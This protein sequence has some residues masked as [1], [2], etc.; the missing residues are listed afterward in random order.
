[1][2]LNSSR[3]LRS[4]AIAAV[5]LLL[6]AGAAFASSSHPAVVTDPTSGHAAKA[7]DALDATKS[8]V[9]EHA[10]DGSG[11]P[12][13]KESS[14][15]TKAPEAS[16][17]SEPTKAPEASESSEPTE[18][19]ETNDQDS[20]KDQ[21]LDKAPEAGGPGASNAPVAPQDPDKDGGFSGKD[22][23]FSGHLGGAPVKFGAIPGGFGGRR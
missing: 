19:A 3:Y 9:V 15:P 1:M 5:P 16:E 6:I 18:A 21:D 14:E 22:G 17:S 13:A 2:N 8:P 20:S 11:A 4:F 7:T 23:G 10:P 12:E